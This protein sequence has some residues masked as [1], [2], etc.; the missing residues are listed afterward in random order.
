MTYGP[1][2]FIPDQGFNP[3]AREGR[4]FGPGWDNAAG[5]G[6]RV[7]IHAPVRGATSGIETSS[8][9]VRSR[10]S[11]HAPVRGATTASCR[12]DSI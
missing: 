6:K 7:S 11:I 9:P 2:F 1:G 5:R 8:P 12:G 3:R 10:V 4:D